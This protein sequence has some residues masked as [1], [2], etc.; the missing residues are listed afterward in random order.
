MLGK[1]VQTAVESAE[2][3]AKAV[4]EA[5]EAA[6]L[7][8]RLMAAASRYE[9]EAELAHPGAVNSLSETKVYFLDPCDHLSS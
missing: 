4:A 1:P 5:E 9:Q 8:T 2:A 3:A 6:A 7:A